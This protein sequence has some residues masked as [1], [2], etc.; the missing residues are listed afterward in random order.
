MTQAGVFGVIREDGGELELTIYSGNTRKR[1]AVV[2][3]SETFL[4][5]ALAAAVLSPTVPSLAEY[6]HR[7]SVALVSGKPANRDP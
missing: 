5:L 2:V 4:L 3:G 7:A 1:I 6:R